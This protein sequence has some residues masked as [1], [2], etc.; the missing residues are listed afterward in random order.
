MNKL[1]TEI[2]EM[3][4]SAR[5]FKS[6]A[7]AIIG[8]AL[9]VALWTATA[10]I[11]VAQGMTAERMVEESLPQGQTMAKANKPDLL[12]AV[13]SAVKKFP[14][15]AP[16][17]VRVAA[18]ARPEWSK[19]IM[20]TAFR[21]VGTSDCGLLGRIYRSLVAADPEN[22][23]ALTE[24]AIELAPSCS[25]TFQP[26]GGGGDDDDG[27]VFGNA[28]G[29]QNPPP[30][31]IGG[32]GGQGNVVAV[33]LNGVTRFFSPEGAEDFLN[34]NPGATLGACGVTDDQNQ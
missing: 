23:N 8:L 24:L 31:S 30:G 1:L 27:G 32:G 28:P 17:I 6:T 29:N 4:F 21:C 33:C 20:R 15:S 22:A 11:S 14:K 19:D 16:Q 10:P 5:L 2:N 9:G 26:G 7:I 25:G 3:H 12:S 34:G 18:S 13:C